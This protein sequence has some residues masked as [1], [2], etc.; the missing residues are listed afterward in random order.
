[1]DEI[2]EQK[3]VRHPRECIR[4]FCLYHCEKKETRNSKRSVSECLL[5]SCPLW[6]YRTGKLKWEKPE[7][8]LLKSEQ[9]RRIRILRA[10]RREVA[11]QEKALR[12]A[13][14]ASR[15]EEETVRRA[16]AIAREKDRVL[17]DSIT[18]VR[19]QRNKVDEAKMEVMK[20]E[21]AFYK[22]DDPDGI[23]R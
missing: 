3:E 16:Q 13:E 1:M 7:K 4:D 19:N 21:E 14:E 2:E 22:K 11:V 20:L 8:D 9:N 10:A 23:W 6:F 5:R 12:Q 17:Q 18:A 15:R